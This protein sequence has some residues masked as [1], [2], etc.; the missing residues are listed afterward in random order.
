MEDL[1]KIQIEII[2]HSSQ[3]YQTCGDWFLDENGVM[4]VRIS[5]LGTEIENFMVAIHEVI[6]LVLLRNKGITDKDIDKFDFEFEERVKRGEA[7]R[8]D[9]PGFASDS[10]YL[11]EHTLATSVELQM[12]ALAKINWN[13]YS[14]K[15]ENLFNG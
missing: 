3:R 2:P 1:K 14:T 10:P 7:G 13:E 6:E 15:I 12:C 11:Q 9:E 4:Q 8:N 5:N